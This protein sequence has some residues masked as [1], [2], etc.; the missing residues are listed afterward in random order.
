MNLYMNELTVSALCTRQV[1]R[2]QMS[3]HSASVIKSSDVGKVWGI[4]YDVTDCKARQVHL[5]GD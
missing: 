4:K 5:Q 2:S 3:L 1:P